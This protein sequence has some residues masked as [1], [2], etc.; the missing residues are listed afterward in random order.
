M[1]ARLLGHLGYVRDDPGPFWAKA[2]AV[3]TALLMGAL[4][5]LKVTG[6]L[7]GVP[8]LVVVVA[9]WGTWPL[10]WVV[11][12]AVFVIAAACGLVDMR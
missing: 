12:L 10:V 11:G 5:I 1:I 9:P 8:W 4:M 3:A 2:A 7:A 6:P